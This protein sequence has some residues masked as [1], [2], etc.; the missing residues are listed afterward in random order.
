MKYILFIT[1]AFLALNLFA[2]ITQDQVEIKTSN[3]QIEITPKKG[4]HINDKAPASATFDNLEAIYHPQVKTEQKMRFN[5]LPNIKK[6]NVKFFVCDDGKTVC[7]QHEK[8]LVLNTNFATER[9]GTSAAVL[10]GAKTKLEPKYLDAKKPTLLIFSAPWCPAC[11]RLHSETFTQASVKKIFSK[12]NVQEINIDL[13]ENEKISDQF[14]VKA[15]PTVVLLNT[16][17]EEVYRW[18][19]YQTA[20]QFSKELS[21]ESKNTEAIP[22]LKEKANAGDKKAALKLAQIYSSQMNWSEAVKYYSDLKDENSLKQ[23][24]SCEINLLSDAKDEN[25]KAKKE[26]LLGLEK[27]ISL[28]PSKMDALRWKLDFYKTKSENKEPLDLV[29]VEKL[30]SQLH[31]LVTDKKLNAFFA[32][33]TVGDLAGFE[34]AEILDMRANTE[35]ILGKTQQKKKTHAEMADVVLKTKLDIKYPGKFISAIAYLTEAEKFTEA[36]DLLKKLIAKYPKTYV[37]HQ[38]YANFLSKQKRNAE[39]LSKI[40]EAIKYKEGNE[41]K[42]NI[43]KI[44][45]LK[46]LNDKTAALKLIDETFKL[47]SLAPEKYKNTEKQLASLKEELTKK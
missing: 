34:K 33:S 26:Y 7:E 20:T 2:G 8:T 17:G 6:A 5:V 30:N 1:S 23:K 15:I 39:A 24:L 46:S 25:D 28:T 14:S 35:D 40:D 4:F 36:E 3:Y 31:N 45:I 16:N 37:Y 11:I 32:D 12:L 38:R 27:A 19:D 44:K 41:P 29:A 10:T 21:L 43:T 42:L 18:L 13:I 22:A 47:T 9:S